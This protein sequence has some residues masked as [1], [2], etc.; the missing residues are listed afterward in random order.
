MAMPLCTKIS[1]A[2]HGELS[3][4]NLP[5]LVHFC[6]LTLL[7]VLA[8]GTVAHGSTIRACNALRALC[9]QGPLTNLSGEIIEV[10]TWMRSMKAYLMDAA[11]L[12]GI[13]L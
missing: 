1:F 12:L 11:E 2:Q 6:D 3:N 7:R 8:A 9:L 10:C 13:W 4:Y 5:T